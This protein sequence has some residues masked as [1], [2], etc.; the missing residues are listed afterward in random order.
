MLLIAVGMIFISC[1]KDDEG[2]LP[3]NGFTYDGTTYALAG[4][5][6][7]DFSENFG[8]NSR[9]YDIYLVSSGISYSQTNEE[10]TGSGEIIY[11]DLN[12]NSTSQFVPGTFTWSTTRLPNTIVDG[13]IGIACNVVSGS[14]SFEDDANG[15]TVTVS[16]N[17]TTFIIDFTLTLSNGQ[18]VTG[19]YSGTLQQIF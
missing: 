6:I 5:F 15:G 9:D 19:S 3:T 1:N 11:L 18:A 8:L 10:F 17:G 14:C 4:G 13:G 7:E 12:V 2:E 16:Q